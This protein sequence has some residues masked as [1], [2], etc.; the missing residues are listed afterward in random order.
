[1]ELVKKSFAEVVGTALLVVFGCGVAIVCGADSVAVSLAFGLTIIAM[2]YSI[3]NVSGCHVNPAVSLAMLIKK[4]ITFKEFC[5]YVVSQLVGAAVG[6]L[7]LMMIFGKDCGF[8]ANLIQGG[9][10]S[11][12][13]NSK[14]MQYLVALVGEIVLTFTFV[15]V[16]LGVTSK[17]KY[18]T[19][20]GV[21]I[22]LTLTLV[23]LLGLFITGTSVN[24]ARSLLPAIFYLF[25]GKAAITQ[26]WVFIVGPLVGA[27]LAAL[28]QYAL[29]C[30]CEK[31]LV[32]AKVEAEPEV[33][34]EAKEVSVASVKEA[35][36]APAR[37]TT[38][39]AST[40]TKKT[41]TTKTTKTTNAK[42]K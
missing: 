40:T 16:I 34:S 33:K 4:K 1:M 23:H 39:K 10:V 18:S 21:V 36:K 5:V 27:A 41:A 13:S 22:G 37:P 29:E 20:S 12:Y 19:I 2:A 26:V 32:A 30:K 24:P 7:V 15:L 11:Q 17:E 3:G 25:T 8:G 28:F 38:K 31:K 42:A 14:T 9:I 6:C 35:E